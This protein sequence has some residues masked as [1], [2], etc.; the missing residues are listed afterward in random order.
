[1][2]R[3]ERFL[4]WWHAERDAYLAWGKLLSDTVIDALGPLIHPV[5]VSY[6]LK[7]AVQPRLKDDQKLVEKAFYRNKQYVDPYDDITDKVGTRF[8]VLLGRQIAS[9]VRA[10]ESI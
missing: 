10:L 4:A 3:E 6:F 1:M 2:T 5:D 7:T 9:V 8:V